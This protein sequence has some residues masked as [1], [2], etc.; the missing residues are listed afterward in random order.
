MNLGSDPADQVVRFSLNGT[1]T[2]LKLSGLAAK[3]FAMF[4]YAVFKDQKKTHGKTH[5]TRMLQ[6]QRPLK[7]FTVPSDRMKE[8]AQ[9]ARKRGLLFVP[10]RNKQHPGQIEIVVFADDAAKV[11][12]VLDCLNLD[13]VKARAGDAAAQESP[14]PDRQAPQ[15]ETP[16]QTETVHT[17][18]GEVEF[19]V[20][21][22]EDAFNMED[23]GNFT[24]GR[25]PDTDT[26]AEKNPSGHS[27]SSKESF[28]DSVGNEP[29]RHSVR[30]ELN[31]IRQQQANKKTQTPG[32]SHPIS[33]QARPKKKTKGKG[34]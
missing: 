12:R 32:I 15:T 6:E 28:P 33:N 13:F 19:E 26:P 1:E 34:R 24:Q 4:L 25:E 30:Q 27:F 7:F 5:L 11:N 17:Q 18:D 3:N 16:P 14:A 10:I 31:E 22:F 8:F 29:G 9:Q 2:A 20:G 23:A 21:G